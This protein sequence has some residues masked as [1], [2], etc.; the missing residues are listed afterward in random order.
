MSFERTI[1]LPLE[2]IGVLVGKGGSVKGEIE[3]RCGIALHVDSK[4]G[5]VTISTKGDVAESNPFKAVDVVTAIARGFSPERA[6]KLFDDD[7]TLGV[8]DLRDYVGK[9]RTSLERVKGRVIGLRGKARR[10]IEELTGAYLSIYGRTVAIMGTVEEVKLASDAVG[11]LASGSEHRSVYKMLEKA[12]AKARRDRL[13][14][15]ESPY[16]FGHE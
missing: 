14:L 13:Q 2:R 15:W 11:M 8:I 3:E 6:F 7:V 5:E 9:S 12:R 16:E 1:K 10:V 4:T